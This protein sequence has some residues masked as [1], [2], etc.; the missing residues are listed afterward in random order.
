MDHQNNTNANANANTTTAKPVNVSSDAA[1]IK[2]ANINTDVNKEFLRACRK[3]RIDILDSLLIAAGSGFGSGSGFSIDINQKDTKKQNGHTGL[4]LACQRGHLKVVEKLIDYGADTSVT[5]SYGYTPFMLACY[6]GHIN[7]IDLL[8]DRCGGVGIGGVD[9]INQTNVKDGSTGLMIACWKGHLKVVERLINAGA[10]VNATSNNGKTPFM[11]ACQYGHWE[12]MIVLLS[13]SSSSFRSSSRCSRGALNVNV[14]NQASSYSIPPHCPKDDII[15]TSTIP[16]KTRILAI[17]DVHGDITALSEFLQASQLLHPNS[18]LTNPIWHGGN[19][20]LVQCGDILD[21]GPDELFCL[22]YISSL[23]RQAHDAGGKVLLLHG[24]HECLNSAGDFRYKDPS[25]AKKETNNNAFEPGGWLS[26]P[27]LQHMNVA[28]VVGKTLFVHGGLT[29]THLTKYGGLEAMN[30]NV[31]NW[32][33]RTPIPTQQMQPECMRGG[34]EPASPVWMRDYSSPADSSPADPQRAQR[35]IDECLEEVSREV[36][37]GVERVVMGHTVQKQINSA[38]QNKAWR[39]DVGTFVYFIYLFSIYMTVQCTAIYRY[40]YCCYVYLN[41]YTLV[42]LCAEK[43]KKTSS[44][45]FFFFSLLLFFIQRCIQGC[46]AWKAGSI[47][48]YSLW[49]REQ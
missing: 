43:K 24:N 28:V 47:G 3:G 6:Y 13:S 17:G 4:S 31:R 19:S 15:P 34:I 25:L 45:F 11:I 2:A 46:S 42:L 26:E 7:I 35:M 20:I 39:I 5:N 29:K 32:Y 10:N 48:N 9:I 36:G 8:I 14:S 16:P 33:S 23:A 1:N 49:R 27:L 41:F 37:E 44:S 18:T 30:A 38:L 40:C 21:R 22:R 12:I